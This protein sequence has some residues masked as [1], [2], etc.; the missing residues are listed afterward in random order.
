MGMM[1]RNKGKRGEREAAAI[2]SEVTGRKVTRRVRQHDGDSDL[3]GLVGFSI[4]VK[5]ASRVTAAIVDEWWEQA[6]SHAD[7]GHEPMLM[8]RQDRQPWRCRWPSSGGY[9]LEGTPKA[10]WANTYG[11]LRQTM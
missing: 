11:E 4:E 7:A 8:Y 2:L 3:V 6:K 1:Q 9:W 10:W 5:V